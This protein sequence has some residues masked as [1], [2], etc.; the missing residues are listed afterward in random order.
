ML[1]NSRPLVSGMMNQVKNK[2]TTQKNARAP[3]VNAFPMRWMTVR[4]LSE[5]SVL[6]MP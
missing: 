4:K 3:N 5:T 1:S 6:E 2:V